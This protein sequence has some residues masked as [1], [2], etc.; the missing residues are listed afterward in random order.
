MSAKPNPQEM[1]AGPVA[2]IELGTTSIRMEVAQAQ[3]GRKL[4]ILESLQQPVSLGRDTFTGGT[5]GFE[6]T[7]ACVKALRSF[8][9]ILREYAIDREHALTAVATSAVREAGNR[10]AFLDRLFIATGLNVTPLDEAEVNRFTYLAVEPLLRGGVVRRDADTAVVEVGGGSTDIFTLRAGRVEHSHTYR[11]GS[12]RLRQTLRDYRSPLPELREIM[13]NQI[14]RTV[15]QV[16]HALPAKGRIQMLALGGDARFAAARFH[17]GGEHAGVVRLK[18]RDLAALAEEALRLSVDDLVKR[19]HV[20]YPDAETL[21]PA[22]LTYLSMARAFKERQILVGSATL[23]EGLL[24]EM[25]THGSWTSEFRKQVLSSALEIGRRY[26]FDRE[27]AEVVAQAAAELFEAL[28]DEHGLNPRYALILRTAALLHEIGSYVSNRSHHKHTMYLIRN[29]DIFGLGA[30]DLELTALTA[31]YHRRAMPRPTH[32]EYSRLDREGRVAVAKLAALLRV[33]DAL[34]RGVRGKRRARLR[35]SVGESRVTIELGGGDLT[36]PRY[37]LREK[38][39][40][41]ERVFGKRVVLRNREGG[42]AHG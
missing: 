41:F 23:R 8:D 18:V 31:R 12:L 42:S 7:E 15:D 22:L 27:H 39:D 20:S 19:Y 28:Q 13:E 38:G 34:A 30:R 24:R 2:V 6:T 10:D 5:I 33:A 9:R 25:V 16:R 32:E 14:E 11:L 4:D 3:R 1:Q 40:M 17:P 37:A 21:G 35:I 29:S 36:L 26:A